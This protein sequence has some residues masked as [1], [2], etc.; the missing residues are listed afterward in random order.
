MTKI[1]IVIGLTITIAVIIFGQGDP[2]VGMVCVERVIDGDTVVPTGNRPNI[3]IARIDAPELPTYE[4]YQAKATA[5]Y[6]LEGQCRK[7]IPAKSQ[8]TGEELDA[9]GRQVGDFWIE[10]RKTFFGQL[11]IEKGQA[12]RF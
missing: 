5:Q 3:R 9:Y 12:V 1:I 4:G 6:W 11:L 8:I 7:F 10:E 2:S